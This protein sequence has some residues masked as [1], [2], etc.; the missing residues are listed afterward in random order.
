LRTS[1]NVLRTG[2]GR[3]LVTCGNAIAV[4]VFIADYAVLWPVVLVMTLGANLGGYAG[5]SYAKKM[6]PTRAAVLVI[7][8]ACAMSVFFFWKTYLV[9][10]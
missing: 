5:A 3:L 2:E 6:Q 4:A 9:E 7:T 8:I 10:H 1:L